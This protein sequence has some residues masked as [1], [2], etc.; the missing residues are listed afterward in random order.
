[1]SA[2]CFWIAASQAYR[3]D[4]VKKYA[5]VIIIFYGKDRVERIK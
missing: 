5:F 4:K 2:S 1:M 3:N